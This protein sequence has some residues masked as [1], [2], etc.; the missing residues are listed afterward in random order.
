MKLKHLHLHAH[1][2][3]ICIMLVLFLVPNI[4]QATDYYLVGTFNNWT[5]S[6]AYKFNV[7]GTTAKLSL[8]GAQINSGSTEFLIKAVE[9]SSKSW[10][11]KK[12]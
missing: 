12:R 2:R 3:A 11:L 4:V 10:F 9:S 7:S 1:F 8:T 6:D 5:A